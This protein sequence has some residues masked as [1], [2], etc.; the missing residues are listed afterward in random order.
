[1]KRIKDYVIGTLNFNLRDI[2]YILRIVSN[3]VIFE[4]IFHPST[5]GIARLTRHGGPHAFRIS[6]W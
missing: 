6:I 3:P 2:T 4:L 1:M 5:V